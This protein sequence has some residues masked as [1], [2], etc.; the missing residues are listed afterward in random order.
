M[1]SYN[2]WSHEDRV[3]LINL[4]AKVTP[5]IAPAVVAQAQRRGDHS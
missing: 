2:I 4:E 3:R 5:Q 1:K